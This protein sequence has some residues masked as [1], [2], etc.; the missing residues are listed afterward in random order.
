M[1]KDV[2]MRVLFTNQ[3]GAGGVQPPLPLPPGPPRGGADRGVSPRPPL[4]PPPPPPAP[5]DARPR[6]PGLP[7]APAGTSPYR[8]LALA[9]LPPVW[10]AP[11]DEPP[12]TTHFVRPEPLD[13]PGE[14]PPD[15]LATLP[16][17]RPVIHA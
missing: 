14:A 5:L 15:W 10:V 2:S 4:P 9:A 12:P 3:P 7:P 17:G 16:P 6:E 13:R 11:G 1:R 8:Y